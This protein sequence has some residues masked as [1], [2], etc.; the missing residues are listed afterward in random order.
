MARMLFSFILLSQCSGCAIPLIFGAAKV[1]KTTIEMSQAVGPRD[2]FEKIDGI[3][4]YKFYVHPDH[5]QSKGPLW[6][7]WMKHPS[8]SDK[9]YRVWLDDLRSRGVFK[10][11]RKR[12]ETIIAQRRADNKPVGEFVWVYNDDF[13]AGAVVAMELLEKPAVDKTVID[14]FRPSSLPTKP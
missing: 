6:Y 5:L 3:L 12:T 10:T 4:V 11:L 7:C 9:V 14:L 8:I 13:H 1:A 2:N